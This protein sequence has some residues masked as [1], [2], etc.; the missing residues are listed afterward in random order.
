MRNVGGVLVLVAVFAAGSAR[1]QGACHA[2]VEKLCSGIPR[3]GGR[4]AACLKANQA[5]LT[6]ECKAHLDSIARYAKEVHEACA[7]DVASYCAGVTRGKGAVLRC[8]SQNRASLTPACQGVLQGAQEKAAEFR[9]ACGKDVRQFCRGIAPGEGR[10]LAC[11]KSRQADLS[12]GCQA[13]M[14]Q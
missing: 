12:P 3:G 5:Q 2:D 9:K 13:L 1:A 10:V 6:P 8:L 14:G 11:L 4:I 7:D